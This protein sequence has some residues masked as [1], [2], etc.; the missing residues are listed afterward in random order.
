MD[1]CQHYKNATVVWKL[2]RQGIGKSEIARRLQ[3][4]RTS[5]R[6][7]NKRRI[8]VECVFENDLPLVLV[9]PIQLQE[10]FINLISN[11]IEAVENSPREPQVT[12][13]AAVADHQ[14]VAMEVIDNGPGVQ[15]LER[16]FDA[17]VTTK[18]TGMDHGSES[19]VVRLSSGSFC[20][21]KDGSIQKGRYW[22]GI[23]TSVG[24]RFGAQ[25]FGLRE[26][27]QRT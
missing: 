5:V 22:H 8:P 7:Q 18:E 11:A 19:T 21:P 23:H 25:H 2:C 20:F 24:G 9:D 26:Y 12:I 10:V 17:F 6:H 15:N 16:I 4:G 14:A 3:I 13:R 27:R 1:S